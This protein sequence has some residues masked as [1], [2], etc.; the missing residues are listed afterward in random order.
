M[1]LIA[2]RTR[3]FLLL[4]F[5]FPEQNPETTIHVAGECECDLTPAVVE[6]Q[7]LE[8]KEGLKHEGNEKERPPLAVEMKHCD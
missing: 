2:Q 7:L 4:S 5:S 3:F 1:V 8:V 6:K